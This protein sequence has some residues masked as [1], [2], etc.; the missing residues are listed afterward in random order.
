MKKGSASQQT[1]GEKSREVK[2]ML[3]MN[4]RWAER[5]ERE[6]ER[7]GRRERSLP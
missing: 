3:E 6:G 2:D 7:E 4:E 1:D 5:K